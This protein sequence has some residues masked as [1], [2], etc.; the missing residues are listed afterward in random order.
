MT[1]AVLLLVVLQTPGVL[2]LLGS[3]RVWV[4]LEA[5]EQAP[6]LVVCEAWPQACCAQGA[7][8]LTESP[9]V[10][11]GGEQRGVALI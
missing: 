9:Q 3:L 8:E 5:Y 7:W 6:L 4:L 10:W 1:E 11:V 2:V